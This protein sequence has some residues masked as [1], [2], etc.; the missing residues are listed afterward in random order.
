MYDLR[1]VAKLAVREGK[2]MMVYELMS[3]REIGNREWMYQLQTDETHSDWYTYNK[4]VDSL[5]KGNFAV[6]IDL[7][8]TGPSTRHTDSLVKWIEH[9]QATNPPDMPP[10]PVNIDATIPMPWVRSP[11]TATLQTHIYAP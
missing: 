6:A 11:Q 3:C 4:A 2:V 10:I 8:R 7:A 5:Y 9:C 1:K